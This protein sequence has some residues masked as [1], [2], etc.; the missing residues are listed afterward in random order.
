MMLGEGSIQS[1]SGGSPFDRDG[2][3]GDAGFDWVGGGSRR[4]LA[5]IGAVLYRTAGWQPK[6]ARTREKAIAQSRKRLGMIY[7]FFFSFFS[8]IC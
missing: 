2:G 1:R 7:F 3:S 8:A 6:A 5:G 4:V